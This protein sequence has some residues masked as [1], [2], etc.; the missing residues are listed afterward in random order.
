MRLTGHTTIPFL[1][2]RTRTAT[3][4]AADFE[5][6]SLYCRYLLCCVSN[7]QRVNPLCQ[8]TPFTSRPRPITRLS[9]VVSRPE[10]DS[11]SAESQSAEL[12]NCSIDWR[13]GKRDWLP[14]SP[15]ESEALL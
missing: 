6:W 14:A 9:R 2:R 12:T 8:S 1:S 5:K 15:L 7:G 11:G 4:S 13:C 3:C 10:H